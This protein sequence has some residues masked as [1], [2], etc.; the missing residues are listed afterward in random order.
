M[1]LIG[2]VVEK[3]EL[4]TN[5]GGA[6]ECRIKLAVPRYSRIGQREPGIV[7]VDVTVFGLEARDCAER[8]SEGSSVGVGG[9]LQDSPPETGLGVLINQLDFL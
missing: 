7:Y 4:R 2:T 9:R 3:P 6:P 8:L 5:R 1:S